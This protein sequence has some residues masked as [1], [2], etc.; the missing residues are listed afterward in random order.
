[1][2]DDYKLRILS[3]LGVEDYEPFQSSTALLLER[4]SFLLIAQRYLDQESFDVKDKNTWVHVGKYK[5][6]NVALVVG[7]GSPH[8]AVRIEH[9]RQYFGVRTVIRIGTC[10]GLQKGQKQGDVILPTAAIRQ[11]GTSA[12]YIEGNWPAAADFVLNRIIADR[13]T[14]EVIPHRIGLLWTTDG[15]LV[16]DDATVARYSKYGILGVDMDT[17]ALFVVSALRN[18]RIASL[19]IISDIPIDQI[20]E[21][22]KGIRTYESWCDVVVP[23][24][25]QLI[26]LSLQVLSGSPERSILS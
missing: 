13:L 26:R 1:M 22:F 3:D 10:G 24:A 23:R 19:C 20:G 21:D 8:C 2:N 17:S 6:R 9:L 16:E 4:E 5:G 15:R 25:E 14:S 11:E 7:A 12:C 18:V